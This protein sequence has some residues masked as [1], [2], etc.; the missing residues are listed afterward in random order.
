M[1]T[2][3]DLKQLS[4]AERSR[5]ARE[6]YGLHSEI[7]AGVD[8]EA[9]DRYV[10]QS[11]ASESAL[12]VYR[13]AAGR[14]VGYFVAHVYEHVF[15]GRPVAVCRG[16][17]GFTSEARGKNVIVTFA[18]EVALRY[19]LRHPTRPMYYLGTLIHPSSYAQLHRFADCVYPSP[20]EPTPPPEV[21]E[22]LMSLSEHFGL[23]AVDPARPLVREVGWSTRETAEEQRHWHG[24]RS[25]AVR[26]FLRENPGYERGEGLLTLSPLTAGGLLRLGGRFARSKVSR[27]LGT[28]AARS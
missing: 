13:D 21:A 8:L 22:L 18:L 17:V 5:L 10:F 7:F 25:P 27:W 24:H 20:D 19:K 6:L 12:R 1:Q 9:F 2:T 4:A 23:R 11:R 3:I 16:E 26:F 15:R 28:R 14:P